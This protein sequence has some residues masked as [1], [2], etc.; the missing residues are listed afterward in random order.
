MLKAAFSADPVTRRLNRGSLYS[1]IGNARHTL[2]ELVS[3][4]CT[5]GRARPSRNWVR[6][7]F[8]RLLTHERENLV[9]QWSPA[10]VPSVRNWPDVALTRARLV[11]EL[12]TANGAMWP[13]LNSV[14]DP[15]RQPTYPDDTSLR[16]HN[17]ALPRRGESVVEVAVRDAGRGLWGRIDR[18]E[19]RSG[20]VVV[21]DLKSGIGVPGD[22][23]AQ[24]HR[25]QMLF[26]A[27]VVQAAYGIWPLLE[28]VPVDGS[29]V[30]IE[31]QPSDVESVRASALRDRR[32]LDAALAARTIAASVQP[33]ASRCA[34]CPF[35]VVCPSLLNQWKSVAAQANEPLKRAVS[36]CRGEVREVRKHLSSTDIVISQLEELTAPAGEVTVT[37]LPAGLEA[38]VG[39]SVAISRLSPAGSDRVLRAQWD[40]VL[41]FSAEGRPTPSS[42]Q[43][44]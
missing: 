15:V 11:R 42:Q 5:E 8:G 7:Q 19:N 3:E 14:K 36:L 4:G 34:W 2:V 30:Q 6:D 26:Y 22:Q 16:P 18:L 24:Q 28:V 41:W 38:A 17:P 13:D 35:Q 1:A 20:A 9:V 10:D 39:D 23:L 32:G 44:H 12:G 31:Y 27:G 43:S 37:R 40:S 25:M 33:T 29:S 21:V